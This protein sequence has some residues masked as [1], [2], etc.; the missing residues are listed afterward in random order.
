MPGPLFLLDLEEENKPLS[1]YDKSGFFVEQMQW[2][3]LN[4]DY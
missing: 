2:M 3:Q 1:S 4:Y